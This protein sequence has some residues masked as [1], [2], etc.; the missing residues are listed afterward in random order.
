[1]KRLHKICLLLLAA[2]LLFAPLVLSEGIRIKA[3]RET[4]RLPPVLYQGTAT[5]YHIVSERT[6]TGSV[7]NWLKERAQAF[8]KSHHGAHLAIE[9]M[10]ETDFFE[11]IANGRPADGYSFFTGALYPEFFRPLPSLLRSKDSYRVGITANDYAIP[12][13]FSCDVLVGKADIALRS[14]GVWAEPLTAA[15]LDILPCE[16]KSA[17]GWILDLNA[18]AAKVEEDTSLKFH[19]L[20]GFTAAVCYLGISQTAEDESVQILTDFYEFLVGEESQTLLEQLGAF[21]VL[22]GIDPQNDAR[23]LELSLSFRTVR[24]PDPFRWNA[25]YDALCAEAERSLTEQSAKER[26]RERFQGLFISE[27]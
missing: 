24:A 17:A 20:D 1:M 11:R 10:S 6:L 13:F 25:E 3:E 8:E 27:S 9:G 21:S 22:D 19:P 16:Q 26:F 7:T 5:L 23:L 4:D 2:A 14:E 12:Y 15:R 18:A